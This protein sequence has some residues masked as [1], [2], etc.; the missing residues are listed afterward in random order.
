M[1]TCKGK[2]EILK[3]ER[4]TRIVQEVLAEC[5]AACQPGVTTA[6]I[7]R[8]ADRGIRERGAKPAFLGYR[9]FP[10]SVCI[11][12]NEEVV[13]GI[14]SPKRVLRAGDIIGLDLGAVVDGYFGDA[15]RT[16]MIDPVSDAVREL[17]AATHEALLAGVDAV[18]VGGRIG[19]IGAAV[20]AVARRN[21]YGVVREF[22]GHG[23]GT[24]LHEEPQVPNYGP[25]GRREAI[26]EGMT[27]AI[28]P[29]FNLGTPKVVVGNDGWTVRTVDGKPSAHFE[30]TVVA[31]SAGPAVLGFGRFS[32][33][34]VLAGAPSSDEYPEAAGGGLKAHVA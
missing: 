8:I 24:S 12:I 20:E 7:D 29:M 11:S 2:A 22:V 17:V 27:L 26:R 5:M 31:T 30:H 3:M 23:I 14:P 15:A 9:G 16:A 10:R 25:A 13:H 18:R 34:R 1:I 28:E 19:D 32:E 33:E 6:E 21:G 4:A